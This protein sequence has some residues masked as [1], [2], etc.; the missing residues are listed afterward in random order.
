MTSRSASSSESR[1]ACGVAMMRVSV[2][3]PATSRRNVSRRLAYDVTPAQ[4][5]R[6]ESVAGRTRTLPR[7]AAARSRASR[8]TY[9]GGKAAVASPCVRS[10]SRRSS[11]CASCSSCASS[12]TSESSK[13][14]VERSG[15][16][17]RRDAVAPSACANASTPGASR[18]SR[19]ASRSTRYE[20]RSC[21][22]S[23]GSSF[24]PARASRSASSPAR[25]SEYSRAGS[26]STESV[27]S[28][29]RCVTGSKERIVSISSPKSSM[30]IGID[31]DA[32]YTSKMPPR[33]EKVP[34]SL[35]SATGS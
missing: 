25:S 17:S 23:T 22:S 3:D 5:S 12:R 2:P 35:T 30:R 28:C 4:P 7:A 15:R 8:G 21:S 27:A 32:G 31:A 16:C 19:S 29:D 18:P 9:G 34:G 26:T 10:S 33:R 13:M 6:T 20:R 24:H 14:T 1:A 11:A